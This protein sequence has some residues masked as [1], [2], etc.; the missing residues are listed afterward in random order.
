MRSILRNHLVDWLGRNRVED[1]L[2]LDN[3]WQDLE[4]PERTCYYQ[5]IKLCI[6]F[7]IEIF[8]FMTLLI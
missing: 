2:N 8:L 4:E 3:V 6:T 1:A 7:A 5:L